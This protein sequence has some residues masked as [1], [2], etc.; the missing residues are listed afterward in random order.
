MVSLLLT[1]TNCLTNDQ[2]T[3]DFRGPN[4]LVRSLNIFV[5]AHKELQIK[6]INDECFLQQNIYHINRLSQKETSIKCKWFIILYTWCASLHRRIPTK[7]CL[8]ISI[9]QLLEKY[10][11]IASKWYSKRVLHFPKCKF[12]H[13][14]TVAS[15]VISWAMSRHHHMVLIGMMDCGADNAQGPNSI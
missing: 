13:L 14:L 11:N 12:I 6:L 5:I 1:W 3:N 4:A 2:A 8:S 15:H 10:W 9:N 7:Y